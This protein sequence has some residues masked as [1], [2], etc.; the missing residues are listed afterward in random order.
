MPPKTNVERLEEA[1][2][3]DPTT[4]SPAQKADVNKLSD[5]EVAHLISA[6]KTVGDYSPTAH[7][8]GRPWIL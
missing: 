3:L 4:L 7:P 6:R 8:G 1:G 2:V 5:P